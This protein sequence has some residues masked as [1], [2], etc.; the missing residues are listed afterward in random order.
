[1]WPIVVSA[2]KDAFTDEK[3][4]LSFPLRGHSSKLG[5]RPTADSGHAIP[6]SF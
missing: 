1:M 5:P 3:A 6:P 2:S 4:S